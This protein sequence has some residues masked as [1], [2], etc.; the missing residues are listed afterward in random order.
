MEVYTL[1]HHDPSGGTDE[2]VAANAGLVSCDDI[3]EWN[4]DQDMVDSNAIIHIVNDHMKNTAE[5][6]KLF[7]FSIEKRVYYDITDTEC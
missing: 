7:D 6:S 3:M 5:V 1:G 4:L 2:I